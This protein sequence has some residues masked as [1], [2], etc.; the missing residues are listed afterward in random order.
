MHYLRRIDNPLVVRAW[1]HGGPA[2]LGQYDPTQY[3]L[4][5]GDLPEGYTL[6]VPPAPLGQRLM[7]RFEALPLAAQARYVKVMTQVEALLRL[8]KTDLARYLIEHEPA[9]HA[10]DEPIRTSFLSEF[11]A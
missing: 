5:A 7:T 1:G 11:P 8:G 3:E 9:I 6:E 10:D 4:V 2:A